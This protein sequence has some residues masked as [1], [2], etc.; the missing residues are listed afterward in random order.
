MQILLSRNPST[1]G[2]PMGGEGYRSD[3]FLGC[4]PI[5]DID[6]EPST[7]GFSPTPS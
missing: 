6:E 4:D 1:L 2:S 5:L 7:Q 3:L